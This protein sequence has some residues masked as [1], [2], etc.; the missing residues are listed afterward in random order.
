MPDNM[1]GTALGSCSADA[2]LTGIGHMSGT[3]SPYT[4]LSPQSLSAAVWNAIISQY[5]E[6]GSTG[7]ALADAGGAGNPWSSAVSGN[8]NTGSFGEMVA[9]KLLKTGSYLGLK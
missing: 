4:E 2:N 6:A 8:T 7:E 3:V 1:I 5:Q 9:K